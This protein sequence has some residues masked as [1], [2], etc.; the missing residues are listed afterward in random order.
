VCVG[1][2]KSGRDGRLSQEK[3]GKAGRTEGE[4]EKPMVRGRFKKK[5]RKKKENN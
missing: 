3:G 4:S 5:S 2:Q 1:K